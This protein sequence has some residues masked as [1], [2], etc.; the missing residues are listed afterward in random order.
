MRLQLIA[1]A[2][3]IAAPATAAAQVESDSGTATAGVL[4]YTDD[5]HV[6]VWSPRASVVAP[7]PHDIM[8]DAETT[9]DALTAASA[10]VVTAAS[11]YAFDELR[12]EGGIGARIAVRKHHWLGA[13]AIVSDEHDYTSLRVGA[14]WLAELARRNTTL[15]LE[16][17]ASF[18][19]VGRAGDPMFAEARRGHRVT[20]TLTQVTDKRGYIDLVLDVARDTGYLASPYRYVP[21][22]IGAMTAYALPERVPDERSSL[23]GLVRVRRSVAP[24]WYGHVDYR[25][26]RDNW[27]L[28]SHTMSA[29][30]LHELVDDKVLVGLAARGYLQSA[31]SF[32]RP[33]YLGDDGAPAW[34]TRDRTLGAANTL[35]LSAAVDVALPWQELRASG[36]FAVVRFAWPDDPIQRRR[37]AVISSLSIQLPF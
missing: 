31:A 19:T 28:T 1:V 25:L 9:V 7:A 22:T 4:I 20:S 18:D 13:R 11:P 16:Y 32:F 21:I 14:L 37:D 36:S 17:M 5:D 23:A 33:S 10:D 34:R 12:V 27:D 3:L 29:Q 8:L 26:C 35:A 15:Q 6:T 24:G 2:V 30:A